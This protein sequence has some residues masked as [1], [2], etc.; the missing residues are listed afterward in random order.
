MSKHTK[1][2]WRLIT[3]ASQ[4]DGHSNV[5]IVH[6][7]YDKPKAICEIYPAFWH[8]SYQGIEDQNGFEK[9]TDQRANAHLLLAAPDMLEA[10]EE[11]YATCEFSDAGYIAHAAI[12]KARG[13]T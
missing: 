6:D 5:M 8:K 11:I 13:N 2:P 7:H 1:G 12:A 10:L 4:D 3:N 9:D